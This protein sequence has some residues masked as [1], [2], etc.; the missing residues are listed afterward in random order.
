[1]KP[2]Y[3]AGGVAIYHAD[4]REVLSQL[5]SESVD[6]VLTDP[7]YGINLKIKYAYSRREKHAPGP[8]IAGDDSL[9]ALRDVLPALDLLLK[10]DRHAYFFA[11]STR[12][13]EAVDAI[14]AWWNIK[15]IL[16]WDKGN[17]G[18]QGDVLAA[19]ARNWEAIVYAN[20]GRRPLAGP[21][22]RAICRYDWNAR[23]DPV[24]PTV[25]PVGLM[26]WLI[27]K[28][29][30]HGELVLDPFCGSGPVLRAARDL[31]R[32]AIGIELEERYC[33]AAVRR[34]QARHSPR[35]HGG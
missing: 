1:V 15:N 29:S 33:E 35:R 16:V 11:S 5:N 7:P 30:R 12:I 2:Y 28:S 9:N 4:A 34:L 25:K 18:T 20:K 21:R 22:P 6:L 10:P 23:K 8:D 14:A 3:R 31:G 13:G 27:Q 17:M 19:Y 32:R 26:A 24:H